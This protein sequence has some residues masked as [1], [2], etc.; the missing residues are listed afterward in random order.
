MVAADKLGSFWYV[1]PLQHLSLVFLLK[2]SLTSCSLVSRTYRRL[3]ALVLDQLST[4]QR[5]LEDHIVRAEA[6]A[7]ASQYRRT[8]RIFVNEHTTLDDVT[9]QQLGIGRS[10]KRLLVQNIEHVVLSLLNYGNYNSEHDKV[11]SYIRSGRLPNSTRG[12]LQSWTPMFRTNR[13]KFTCRRTNAWTG[14]NL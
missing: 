1:L 4:Q 8:V 11:I 5:N 3:G 9:E 14:W 2:V 6:G 10:T 12:K 13:Y 7:K